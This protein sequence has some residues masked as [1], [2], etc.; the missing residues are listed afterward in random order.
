MTQSGVKMF[1]WYILNKSDSAISF[2]NE[3]QTWEMSRYFLIRAM[4]IKILTG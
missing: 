4:L 3:R 2:V 1:A